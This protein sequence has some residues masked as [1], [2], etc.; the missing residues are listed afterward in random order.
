MLSRCV[1]LQPAVRLLLRPAAGAAL[2]QLRLKS[3]VAEYFHCTRA[4]VGTLTNSF[5]K[6]ALR[7]SEPD[8]PIN[9][10]KA[11]QQHGIYVAEL[12]KLIPEVKRKKN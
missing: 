4:V 11:K 9:L 7:Y 8:E 3:D 10:E 2:R 1:R 6:G 12:K 5:I